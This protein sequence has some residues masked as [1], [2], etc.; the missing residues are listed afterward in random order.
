MTTP[1]DR[2]LVADS[3]DSGEAGGR[4]IRGGAVRIATYGLSLLASLVSAPLVIRHL[5]PAQYGY[6]AT[7]TAAVFIISGVTEGGLNTLGIRE[8]A[9]GRTDRHELLR[10]LVGLRIATTSAGIAAAA[11]VA[12]LLGARAVIAQGLLVAGAGLIVT[13]T[14]ETYLIP[15]SAQVR[16]TA[17]SVLGLVQQLSLAMTYV[18]LVV[19]GAPILPLLGA[20]L[21]SGAVLLAAA[22]PLLRGQVSI[23]P[24]F[25]LASWSA[26]VRDTLPYA[27]AAAVGIIYFRETLVINAAIV[28]ARDAGFYAA[29]FRI[30]EVL[31]VVAWSLMTAALPIL[32]RAA[33][34]GDEDRMGY[35]QQRL[36]EVALIAGSGLAAAIVVGAP[37]AISVVA[38]PGFGPAVAVLQI[39]SLAV[40][41]SFMVALFGAMLLSLRMFAVLWRANL[42]AV[43]VATVLALVLIP[44]TG[45][46]GAAVAPTVAEACLALAYARALSRE[47]PALRVSLR[48]L[49]RVLL[50][51]GVALGLGLALPVPSVVGLGVFAVAYLAALAALR[52]IPSEVLAALRGGGQP[53]VT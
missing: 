38:G 3:L 53:P 48:L 1:R 45:I 29:A 42:L 18:A 34:R 44:S 47:R 12:T 40:V 28:P 14:A 15:L 36:F 24:A 11:L 2:D 32:T 17:V 10:N 5:G 19:L 50:A 41:T 23:V 37:F 16:V 35:A 31:T 43:V 25:S 46:D 13:I 30:V 6:F 39:Q 8:F 52:A 33:H 49:P 22:R 9:S 21:V 51:A 4:L 27:I 26:I 7:V 20:T